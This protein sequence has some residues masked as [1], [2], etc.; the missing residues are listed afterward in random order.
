[1]N[2]LAEDLGNGWEVVEEHHLE[3]EYDL[4]GSQGALDL[5]NAV[6]EIVWRR[7]S[8]GTQTELTAVSACGSP[9]AP[10]ERNR[11]PC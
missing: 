4:E 8:S 5:A 1:M 10:D 7:A 2:E 11:K 6:S 3:R 9:S